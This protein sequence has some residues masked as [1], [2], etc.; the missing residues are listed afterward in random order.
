M[1]CLPSHRPSDPNPQQAVCPLELFKPNP[2]WSDTDAILCLLELVRP[3]PLWSDSDAL[4]C[5]KSNVG[6]ATGCQKRFKRKIQKQN[7]SKVSGAWIPARPRDSIRC[8]QHIDGCAIFSEIYDDHHR[9]LSDNEKDCLSEVLQRFL[10]SFCA[11][12][13]SNTLQC[14]AINEDFT[15]K[16]TKQQET[17]LDILYHSKCSKNILA[18][19]INWP[20]GGGHSKKCRSQLAKLNVFG[21]T[22]R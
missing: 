13:L 6:S 8:S 1:K 17:R 9:S 19:Q 21:R 5:W 20:G 16:N 7:W 18:N 11:G 3:N 12:T 14:S 22:G 10:S 2:L 4:L 15:K